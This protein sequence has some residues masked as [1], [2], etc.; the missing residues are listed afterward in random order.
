MTNLFSE[1]NCNFCHHL[2]NN[3]DEDLYERY[4]DGILFC[5][6]CV[7]LYGRDFLSRLISSLTDKYTTQY[8]KNADW[9]KEGF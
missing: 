9:K 5:D 2:C 4:V 1:T 7:C 3:N 8:F 6:T